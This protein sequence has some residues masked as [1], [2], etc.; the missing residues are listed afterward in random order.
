MLQPKDCHGTYTFVLV[1]LGSN[2]TSHAGGPVETVRAAIEELGA[3]GLPT[4]RISRIFRTPA[5]PAGSGPDFAN[6][7]V[8]LN[9]VFSAAEVLERLHKIEA[10]FARDRARRWAPRTLDLD[11]IAFADAVLPDQETFEAWFNLDGDRQRVE[12][13]D[14]L[15]VP[16]PRMHERGFVLLPLCD[17]APDWRHPFLGQTARQLAAALPADAVADVEPLELS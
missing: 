15:I 11:L 4:E 8:A 7:V 6:A 3:E 17:V 13:P 14:R 16:H 9:T 1:A 5:F 10:G 12:A 2:V